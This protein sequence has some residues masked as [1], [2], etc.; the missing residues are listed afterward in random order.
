VTATVTI[1]IINY[2]VIQISADIL[3]LAKDFTALMVIC[4]F[5]YF[6]AHLI[7]PYTQNRELSR[8]CL[9]EDCFAEMLKIEV[10]TSDSAKGM[11]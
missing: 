1:A 3:T 2:L 9:N 7:Q 10:T 4:D 5:D 11:G 8:D 6:I